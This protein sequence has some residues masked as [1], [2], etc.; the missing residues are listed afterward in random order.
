MPVTANTLRELHRIHLQ[1]SELNGRLKRGP[2][3]VHVREVSLANIEAKLA[4]EQAT[5]LEAK[6]NADGKQLDLKT[7]E[8]KILDYKTKLNGAST[9]KEYQ[10]LL[11]QIAAAEMA[12]SVLAD[13]I[14]ET[15]EQ[16]DTLEVAVAK[17]KD[18]VAAAQRDLGRVQQEVASS[19][20]SI[21]ADIT[22]LSGE[23][24]VAEGSLPADFRVDYDRIIRSKQEDGMAESEEGVCT[25]C[26]Q[27]ITMNMQNELAMS[28]PIFCKSCGR[29]LY[30]PESRVPTA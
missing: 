17:A 23:L 26:G 25:G 24:E 15:L 12:N 8:N 16:I 5:V 19:T 27:Q 1:L 6:K 13:E 2:R 20:E 22:R 28:R 11:E 3:Q 9:N 29:L 4:E 7:G 18:N 21:E 30:L 14:L 10:A